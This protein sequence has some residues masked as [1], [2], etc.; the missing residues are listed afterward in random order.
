MIYVCT[1]LLLQPSYNWCLT[2]IDALKLIA[3]SQSFSSRWK[4]RGTD[5]FKTV[6]KRLLTLIFQTA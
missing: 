1:L 4:Y 6:S 3:K 5:M 2:I